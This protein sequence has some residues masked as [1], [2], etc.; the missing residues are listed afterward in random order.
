[1]VISK[2]HKYCF[3]EYPRSASYAIRKEL[4]EFYDG[5]NWL[6]KHS[7]YKDFAQSLPDDF[8][9][10]FVFCSIRNPMRDIISIYNINKTNA[11]GRATPEFWT[12]RKWY[13]RMH[14]LRR[15]EF[16]KKEGDKS[17]PTFFLS[18]FRLPYIKPRIIV[19][20]A[21]VKFDYIIRVENLQ[22][23]FAEVLQKLGL[24]RKQP[25][26]SY[27][28]STK[29]K[30]DLNDYYPNRIRKRA[31]WILGP[32]MNLMGYEFPEEWKVKRIPVLSKLY[33]KMMEPMCH[34][35]WDY[36]NHSK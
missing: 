12:N 35:Y 11:S 13:I 24:E 17:F 10:Y 14:E 15:A 2:K 20:F 29:G 5:E 6:E 1:M 22:K 21:T 31:V 27:N 8:K 28:V 23:D 30:V 25:V 9:D 18:L 19:E 32:M 16:F 3:I 34:I 7:R 26:R 4:L 36:L 33:F